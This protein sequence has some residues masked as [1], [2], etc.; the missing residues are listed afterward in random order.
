M[1]DIDLKDNTTYKFSFEMKSINNNTIGKKPKIYTGIT[2][3]KSMIGLTNNYQTYEFNEPFKFSGSSKY[4]LGV[5]NICFDDSFS[6]RNISFDKL[7]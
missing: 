1:Y 5:E 4:R 6:V 2:W 7:I 3:V